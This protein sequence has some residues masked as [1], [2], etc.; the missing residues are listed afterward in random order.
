MPP[1]ALTA[2]MELT[3]SHLEHSMLVAGVALVAQ[4]PEL[5]ALAAV[6]REIQAAVLAVPG[7][8]GIVRL[9]YS[10]PQ[11]GNG[12]SVVNTGGYTYHTFNSSGTYSA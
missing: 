12:G 4:P 7:G 9:R 10:G 3:G 1:A 5:A 6:S 2:E 8:S 11:R